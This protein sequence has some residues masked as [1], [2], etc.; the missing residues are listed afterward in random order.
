MQTEGH[1]GADVE[2]DDWRVPR[3]SESVCGR[4]EHVL[5]LLLG[6]GDVPPA[7]APPCRLV[8]TG[9]ELQITQRW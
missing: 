7:Q 8:L 6:A 3:A 2:G 9:V 4:E 5:G 1:A